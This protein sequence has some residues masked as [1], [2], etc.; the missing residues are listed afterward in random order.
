[1]QKK[2]MKK[3]GHKIIKTGLFLVKRCICVSFTAG[4]P[5]I[6]LKI[7]WRH[8]WIEI[9]RFTLSRLY[10]CNIIQMFL[11]KKES[12]STFHYA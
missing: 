9:C 3:R 8:E 1:M 12:S 11:C 6:A 5:E 4:L 10:F 2:P 7:H